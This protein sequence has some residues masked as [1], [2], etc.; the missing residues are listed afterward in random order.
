MHGHVVVVAA[1]D[2]L[3]HSASQLRSSHKSIGQNSSLRSRR[4]ENGEPPAISQCRGN[5]HW[6]L[7]QSRKRKE[8]AGSG[9][10]SDNPH[11]KAR[12]ELPLPTESSFAQSNRRAQRRT[13]DLAMES[14]QLLRLVA[15]ALMWA[16]FQCMPCHV[17]GVENM[18]RHALEECPAIRCPG[19]FGKLFDDR[20]EA[21]EYG[22]HKKICWNCHVLVEGPLHGGGFTTKTNN[23]CGD[24]KDIVWPVVWA[25]L[26]TGEVK[27]DAEVHFRCEWLTM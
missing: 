13:Q 7:I 12:R 8:P 5:S 16:K 21:V 6:P 1:N 11:K 18:P 14:K 27:E 4:D 22:W 26:H 25:I 19:G 20:K 2:V 9:G 17:T 23:H 10:D 3:S 15:M 24:D